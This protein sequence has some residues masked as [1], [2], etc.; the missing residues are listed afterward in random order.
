MGEI[1]AV[2]VVVPVTEV[3]VAVVTELV[4][5]Q[6]VVPGIEVVVAGS[7]TVIKAATIEGER[8]KWGRE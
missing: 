4:V 7:V 8:R 3:I 5:K 2:T 1:I 6:T